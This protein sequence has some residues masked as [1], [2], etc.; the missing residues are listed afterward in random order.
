MSDYIQ[1]FDPPGQTRDCVH[2]QHARKCPICGLERELHGVKERLIRCAE[3]KAFSVLGRN[4]WKQVAEAMARAIQE[5]INHD[6]GLNHGYGLKISEEVLTRYN[7]LKG[8]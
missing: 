2:G 8:Q 4:Q 5:S 6:Y 1:K 7:K 3:E